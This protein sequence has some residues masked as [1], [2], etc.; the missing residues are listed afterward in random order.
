MGI[1][2]EITVFYKLEKTYADINSAC[3]GDFNDRR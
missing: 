1:L 3:R 2:V